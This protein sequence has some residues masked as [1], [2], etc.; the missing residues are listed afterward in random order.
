MEERLQKAI[1]KF[2]GNRRNAL[3]ARGAIKRGEVLSD[4]TLIF[5]DPSLMEGIDISPEELIAG[6]DLDRVTLS[7]R[8]AIS[9]RWALNSLATAMTGHEINSS[10]SHLASVVGR[11][12]ER[13][14]ESRELGYAKDIVNRF[15]E[16]MHFVNRFSNQ[17]LDSQ[18]GTPMQSLAAVNREF[19][20]LITSGRL[21]LDLTEAFR[22]STMYLNA[23]TLDF[24]LVNLIRNSC[25]WSSTKNGRGS[26]IIVRL[27]AEVRSYVDR[28]GETQAETVL[29]IEDNGPGIQPD[30]RE[31]IFDPEFS[32]RRSSGIG[33]HLCRSNL[34]ANYMTIVLDENPSD[35]G[36]ATFLIGAKRVLQPDARQ[37]KMPELSIT[38]DNLAGMVEDGKVAELEKWSEI[39]E[40]ACGLAMRLRI[41][42]AKA[43]CEKRLIS[44][45]DRISDVMRGYEPSEA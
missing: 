39:Y 35:L 13:D 10:L 11:A 8:A 24:V 20:G 1:T 22:T 9:E 14:P 31:R 45:V 21:K 28:D 17:H 37:D 12:A 6:L 33:L 32:G 38:I 29:R 3:L 25:Y 36:G 19:S 41:R 2:R 18:H 23:L 30:K 27:D 34:E 42:G 43:D 7:R 5:A 15:R 4:V 16:T 26:E 44:A 40:E